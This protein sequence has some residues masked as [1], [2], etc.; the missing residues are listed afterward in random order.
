MCID[1]P[2]LIFHLM[3]HLPDGS[4]FLH[5]TSRHGCHLES[6]YTASAQRICSPLVLLCTVLDP[7]YI[8]TWQ[9]LLLVGLGSFSCCPPNSVRTLKELQC[10]RNCFYPFFSRIF[11]LL[12][13][14]FQ[15][16]SIISKPPHTLL[17]VLIKCC[18]CVN[19]SLIYSQ[20]IL[21]SFLLQWLRTL[22]DSDF[23]ADVFIC[24]S[25]LVLHA[26]M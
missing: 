13:K 17:F 3:P 5:E 1:C 18:T 6:A 22:R 21:D 14:E 4:S 20:T 10:F 24:Y 16:W 2:S 11:C 12:S 26:S 9:E 19:S 23:C 15:L 8:R 25:V 7:Q